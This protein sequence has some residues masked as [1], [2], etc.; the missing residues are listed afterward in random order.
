MPA[1]NDEIL[2]IRDFK[3]GNAK[4]FERLFEIYHKRLY[5]FI[6]KLTGSKADSEEIV[7]DTFIKIWINRTNFNE[8]YRFDAYLFR[9][10]KNSFISHTRRQ[11]NKRIFEDHLYL[12]ADQADESADEQIIFKETGLIVDILINSMPPKRKE[13]F[14]LQKK[15]GLSRKEISQRLNVSLVT[16]DSHLMKANKQFTEGLK[17]YGLL[18]IVLFL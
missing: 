1:A 5:G 3:K 2:L 4:A 15:E 9:I 6:L 8:S 13:I 12:F 18:A 17:K 14:C 10:A 7:Q 11:I 16:I